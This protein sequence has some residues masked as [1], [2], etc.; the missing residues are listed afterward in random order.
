M[1]GILFS[2]NKLTHLQKQVIVHIVEAIKKESQHS[3]RNWIKHNTCD[4]LVGQETDI[5]KYNSN[6]MAN[7]ENYRFEMLSLVVALSGSSLGL[8]YLSKQLGLFR[9]FLCLLHTSSDRVQRQVNLNLVRICESV[10]YFFVYFKVILLIRRILPVIT[11]VQFCEV[12]K[13]SQGSSID[14]FKNR[15]GIMDIFIS[16]IAKALHVQL[17]VKNKAIEIK[18]IQSFEQIRMADF[19]IGSL[20]ENDSSPN[21]FTDSSVLQGNEEIEQLFTGFWFMRGPTVNAKQA[22]NI[23]ILMKDILNVSETLICMRKLLIQHQKTK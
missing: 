19:Q 6:E 21:M 4:Y 23:I 7:G 1:V 17:K 18:S 16:I 15:P 11:P 10:I 13:I 5:H 8:L 3:I 20:N 12:L 9:D 14:S 2:Q 22:E